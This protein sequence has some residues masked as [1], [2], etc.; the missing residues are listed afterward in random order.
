MRESER[1]INEYKKILP[2][3]QMKVASIAVMLII[4]VVMMTAAT[5]AWLTVSRSP[6]VS[7]IQTTVSANGNLEIALSNP[8]GTQPLESAIGDAKKELLERNL[9]WGNLINLSDKSYGLEHLE[10]RPAALNVSNLLESPLYAAAYGSDGRVDNLTSQFAYTNYDSS[11]GS[12]MFIVPGTTQYGVRAISSVTYTIIGGQ[13]MYI[14]RLTNAEDSLALAQ[15]QYSLLTSVN[16]E[17]KYM[18]T[19][20]AIMGDYLTERFND[21]T[22]KDYK[23][24]IPALWEM[25]KDFGE[26]LDTT[27]EAIV[28]IANLQYYMAKGKEAVEN[29]YTLD[30]LLAAPSSELTANGINIDGLETYK[31]DVEKFDIYFARMGELKADAEKLIPVYW[32]DDVEGNIDLVNI[33]NFMVDINS[34]R[35]ISDDLNVTVG[36]IQP[37]QATGLLGSSGNFAVIQKGALFNAEQRLGSYMYAENLKVTVHY[38]IDVSVSA[39]VYTAANTIYDAS[40]VAKV[41]YAL[42]NVGTPDGVEGGDAVAADTYGMAIDVWVRSNAD[43][44]FLVLEGNTL[45]QEIQKTDENGNKYFT[46]ENGTTV[47]Q[48]V[49]KNTVGEEVINYYT[50]DGKLVT[51]PEDEKLSILNETIVIG[52]EGE[53]RVWNSDV[54]KEEL[55]EFSTT[56]GAGSCYVFY[57]D[58]PQAQNQSLEV[59]DSMTIAFVDDAGKLLAYADLDTESYYADAGR[60]TV[61]L[62]VR[63]TNTSVGT[64][65]NGNPIYAITDLEKGVAKRITA[66]IYVDGTTL[67]NGEVLADGNIQGQLNIQFGI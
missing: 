59:L 53:N 21:G 58:S 5:F 16:N 24:Y 11:A 65:E 45:T 35:I 7:G 39:S 34:V 1:R 41:P 9:T 64:D 13:E 26:C 12:G 40:Q 37:S 30:M 6:E 29:P 33:V 43:N 36:N 60:V 66:I 57:A 23:S 38:L 42:N 67:E 15:S 17:K 55:S 10:L 50:E 52:Y 19:I 2:H 4:S 28:S 44:D 20:T 61:P 27:G 51:I 62:I 3:I 31:T 22:V 32:Q 49:E 48:K 56:Q 47:I 14:S 18:S 25:M 46:M 54:D 8:Q 63:P